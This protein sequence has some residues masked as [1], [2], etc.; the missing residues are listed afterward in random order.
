MT[1]PRALTIALIIS[2]ALNLFLIGG[3]SGAAY[4]RQKIAR[5]APPAQQVAAPRPP[6]WSAGRDLPTEHRQGLRQ[7]MREANQK[8]QANVRQARAERR[9]VWDALPGETFDAAEASRH[10]AAARALDQQSRT[11]VDEAL[12][13]YAATLP[14]AERA[15]LAEGLARV[16]A[17][18]GRAKA[19]QR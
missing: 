7:A 17:P 6:L 8:N 14:Q 3:I 2:G 18:R 4:M 16:Y 19:G 15:A 9:A 1:S 13:G 10:L 5:E 11:E 12:I